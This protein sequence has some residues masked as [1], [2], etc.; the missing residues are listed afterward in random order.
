MQQA[1]EVPM[2]TVCLDVGASIVEISPEFSDNNLP[3]VDH[4]AANAL[5]EL[6]NEYTNQPASPVNLNLPPN[7]IAAL[8]SLVSMRQSSSSEVKEPDGVKSGNDAAYIIN[9]DDPGR[10]LSSSN[11]G[12]GQ[13]E[14][15]NNNVNVNPN[16]RDLQWYLN[17]MVEYLTKHVRYRRDD[18]LRVARIACKKIELDR[19]F[20]ITPNSSTFPVVRHETESEPQKKKSRGP[21]KCYACRKPTCAESS[22]HTST[23]SD[24]CRCLPEMLRVLPSTWINETSCIDR[25]RLRPYLSTVKSEI[26]TLRAEFVKTKNVTEAKNKKK[27]LRRSCREKADHRSKYKCHTCKLPIGCNQHAYNCCDCSGLCRC[28]SITV[29]VPFEIWAQ[30]DLPEAFL[31]DSLLSLF[32][33][34]LMEEIKCSVKRKKKEKL[35]VEDDETKKTDDI[36]SESMRN[37]KRQKRS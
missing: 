29:R 19:G 17:N 12:A 24:I 6:C 13:Q 5:L 14:G 22:N 4:V 15:N 35:L 21:Y 20:M 32:E 30:E 31:D 27:Q 7:A 26:T 36:Q 16:I 28:R 37:E 3:Y 8:R 1:S 11:N 10:L 23:S 9:N 33:E 34:K 25:E 2:S 18:A